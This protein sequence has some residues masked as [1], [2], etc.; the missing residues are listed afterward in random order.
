MTSTRPVTE[1]PDLYSYY[2]DP[3]RVA[4][5][6]E[7]LVGCAAAVLS[8]GGGEDLLQLDGGRYPDLAAML[9]AAASRQRDWAEIVAGSV[10]EFN[11]RGSVH[12]AHWREL[13]SEVRAEYP[14]PLTYGG[15]FD[16]FA[17]VGFWDA[18]DALSVNA[19]FPLSRYGS[20][21]DER[22]G[23]M[24]RRW[25]QI[26]EQLE[27]AADLPL[28][29]LELGWTRSAGATVRPYSY[30]RVEVLETTGTDELTCVHWPSQPADA[31]ERVDA[32]RALGDAVEA[33]AFPRLR[34]FTLWKM[35]TDPAHRS[36]EPFAVVLPVAGADDVDATSVLDR[37]DREY[38]AAAAR[39]RA[40]VLRGR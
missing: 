6:N 20:T 26:G 18:L 39:V 4:A 40:A 34:G 16:Q 13:I 38:L 36:I 2:L 3:D 24:A 35:T 1:I 29:M 33:G 17:Q 23:S 19:Y 12:E 7:R 28:V 10:E 21:G 30:D 8:S 37:F 22:R 14:G 32:M 31:G 15:N 9:D 11:R 27:S 5:V 25:Q